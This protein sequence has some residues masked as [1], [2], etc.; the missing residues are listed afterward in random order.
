MSKYNAYKSLPIN[1]E[2]KRKGS[3]KRIQNCQGSH[4]RPVYFDRPKS[5]YWNIY[6]MDCWKKQEELD[7]YAFADSE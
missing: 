6:C 1:Q 2:L 3:P 4:R 5:H 7:N